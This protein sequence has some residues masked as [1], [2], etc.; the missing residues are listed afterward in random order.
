MTTNSLSPSFGSYIPACCDKDWRCLQCLLSDRT[1]SIWQSLPQLLWVLSGELSSLWSWG[2]GAL[3]ERCCAWQYPEDSSSAAAAQASLCCR[4]GSCCVC[5]GEKPPG[6]WQKW[7]NQRLGPDSVKASPPK[8]PFITS[9][10]RVRCSATLPAGRA[11]QDPQTWTDSGDRVA[12]LRRC[13][14]GSVE[15]QQ[16]LNYFFP[17]QCSRQHCVPCRFLTGRSGSWQAERVSVGPQGGSTRCVGAEMGP[18]KVG[19][20]RLSAR[21]SSRSQTIASQGSQALCTAKTL[22]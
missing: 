13:W 14:W 17:F 10:S 5:G 3:R 9:L 7:K 18:W 19:G 20:S 8:L 21:S 1:G 16:L 11:L 2:G 4:T 15:R 22:L 12:R 6:G